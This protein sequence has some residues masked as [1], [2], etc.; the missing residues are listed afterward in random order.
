MKRQATGMRE[1]LLVWAIYA[2]VAVAVFVTYAWVSPT[3]MYNVSHD[4]LAGAASR[5]LV[6]SNY[7]MSLVALA[8]LGFAMARLLEQPDM[9][10][11]R[12]MAIATVGIVAAALSLVTALPG[13]VDQ[14][15]LDAKP[16]NALPALGVAIAFGLTVAAIRA[17]GIGPALP[18]RRRDTI[19]LGAIAVLVVFGLPW[20]LADLGIYI[21]DILGIGSIVMSKEL[22]ESGGTL[23][24]VHL[25]HHHGLDGILFAVS[26]LILARGLSQLTP[27]RLRFGLSWYLAL[28]LPYG[29]GNAL[30]D[31][32]HEQVVK[33]G[34][35]DWRI[36]EML[37]PELTTAW[38]LIVLATVVGWFSIFRPEASA[39]HRPTEH[40][41]GGAG[42]GTSGGLV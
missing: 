38:L 30:N 32:W 34:W 1:V 41:E 28:M 9:D 37:R 26:A 2:A 14:G 36:P 5:T 12:R 6:F 42:L 13:V 23:R 17:G 22:P 27:G 31:G 8:L 29:V 35:T 15:D 16:V 10:R 40:L 7:S 24:A 4:G 33:R 18:W 39:S 21:G 19:G 11:R 20:I 25:G 3:E